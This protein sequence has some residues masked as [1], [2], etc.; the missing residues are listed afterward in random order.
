M[1]V[2]LYLYRMGKRGKSRDRGHVRKTEI[3]KEI[4][5]LNPVLYVS[6]SITHLKSTLLASWPSKKY[7]P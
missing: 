6:V 7:L 3:N 4:D 5:M 2:H 1:C